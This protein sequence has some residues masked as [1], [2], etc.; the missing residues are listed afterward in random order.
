MDIKQLKNFIFENNQVENILQSIECHHIKYHSS[1]SSGY[2]TCSNRDGDNPN[3]IT[4]Y[5]NENLNCINY[6]RDIGNPYYLLSL[7]CFNRQESFFNCIK[8]L[9]ET[10]EIDY[11]HDF[12]EDIPESL[13]ITKLIYSMQRGNLDQ[14]DDKPL[15]PIS[16]KILNYYYPYVNDLF[17]NDGIDY[18]TQREFEIGYD[19]E[20]N[21]ITIPIYDEIGSFVGVKGPMFKKELL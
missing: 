9:C 7:V 3:A 8:W 2:W 18:L 20:T 21:R 17:Y 13:R 5:A 15:K 16:E 14:E 6:T 11:Y 1:S 19:P 10:L 12:N 4:V